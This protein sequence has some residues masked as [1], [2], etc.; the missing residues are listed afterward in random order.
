MTKKTHQAGGML[1]SIVGFALLR[2]EGVLLPD[3]NQGLQWLVM[4]PFCMWSCTASD[5]DHHWDSCPSKD[6]PSWLFHKA[7]HI[8]A[9]IKKKLDKS[10]SGA[11]KKKSL[12][13]KAVSI[14]NA[15]H[16]SWQTHSD[17]TLWVCLMLI[18]C[19]IFLNL[20]QL[21]LVE[22]SILALVLM[23]VVLGFIAHLV[24]DVLTPEGIWLMPFVWLQGILRLF[25][26]RIKLP[27]ILLKV[28]FV[29]EKPFFATGGKWE[30]II[31][32]VL[33]F[34][35]WVALVWF[36]SILILPYVLEWLPFTIEF[37]FIGG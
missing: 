16:R 34:S 30:E 28:H 13:Y 26:P 1:V 6:Y 24:L 37:N 11:K 19:L 3:V 21:N 32:K 4:Y 20:L 14:F 17:L 8:T 7:L 15:S 27:Q 9:P 23:G 33:K 29:P 31:Q 5:Q 35:T 18:R 10:L 22:T 36:L 2:N 12:F 25:N